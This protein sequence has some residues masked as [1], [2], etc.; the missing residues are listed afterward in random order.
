MGIPA[1][2]YT[3]G[4][5]WVAR[6]ISAVV[7]LIGFRWMMT[8]L[9]AER[10]A[11][12]AVLLAIQGWI[13]LAELGLG[14]ALQN[15]VS[16]ARAQG[17][18]E[19]ETVATATP[20]LTALMVL[21]IVAWLALAPTL[22][23]LLLHSYESVAPHDGGLSLRIIGTAMIITVIASSGSRVLY[24]RQVGWAI[25]LVSAAASLTSLAVYILL[26][27]AHQENVY[28]WGA[29][30]TVP[31]AVG[32]LI[33]FG[34]V[35]IP[36]VMT[37]KPQEALRSGLV[38]HAR[39]F[40]GFAFLSACVLHVDVFII[41]LVLPPRDLIPYVILQKFFDL[42]FGAYSAVHAA[43]WPELTENHS[44]E[45]YKAMNQTINRTM[46][47]G[48]TLISMASFFIFLF[49]PFILQILVPNER[50]IVP[51]TTTFFFS[52]Y[53]IIRVWCDTFGLGLLSAT[54]LVALQRSAL[55]QAFLCPILIIYG[56][57]A[58]GI[59]GAII[60]LTLSF[61]LTSAWI[62]PLRYREITIH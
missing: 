35:A 43:V 2:A 57:R 28:A 16:Q 18:D 45:N 14:S 25:H 47:I 27:T 58:F 37:A 10:Y 55:V 61:I 26:H 15:A 34:V 21:L 62:L 13:I 32:N 48:A 6:A 19:L 9:G 44:L 7:Q 41:A 12:L 22:Q 59:N 30:I 4:A 54:D 33:M 46:A 39:Q 60:G 29:A 56:T 40:A 49:R 1:Y 20:V 38:A 42:A 52:C 8:T 50:V 3:A 51:T 23:G 17:H 36:A 24:A 31:L 5:A 53:F 11:S